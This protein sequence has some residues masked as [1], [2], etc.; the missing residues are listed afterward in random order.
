MSETHGAIVHVELAPQLW[1]IAFFPFAAAV[2]VVY[3]GTTL[4]STSG[5]EKEGT[6]N[7]I[8]RVALAGPLLSL[9]A[10]LFYSYELASRAASSRYFLVH[11]GNLLRI[12]Q[13]DANL[14][15]A[16]DP[17]SATLGIVVTLVGSAVL[18]LITQKTK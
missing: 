5:R 4:A 2:A 14:D 13:L 18:L 11:L 3:F 12:G 15:F 1:S 16:L 9:V 6:L 7:L 10:L 17:L 8:A